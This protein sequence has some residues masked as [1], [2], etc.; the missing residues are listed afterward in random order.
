MLS[1]VSEAI[2]GAATIRAFGVGPQLEERHCRLVDANIAMSLV[3][4]SL[5]R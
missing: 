4:Q 5:N 3:G 1:S 2:S